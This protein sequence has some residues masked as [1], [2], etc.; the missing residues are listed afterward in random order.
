MPKW[1]QRGTVL[2]GIE[3]II[4]VFQQRMWLLSAFVLKTCLRQNLKNNGL[5]SL[6]KEISRQPAI[7]SVARLLVIIFVGVSIVKMSKQSKK[8]MQSVHLEKKKNIR[9][10]NIGTKA[11]DEKR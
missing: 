8:E 10:F 6:S 3:A 1:F 4:L 2:A 5:I 7:D 9:K 11:L